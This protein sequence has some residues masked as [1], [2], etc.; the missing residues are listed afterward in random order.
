MALRSWRET[1]LGGKEMKVQLGGTEK[2]F[3]ILRFFSINAPWKGSQP[4]VFPG[5]NGKF[6]WPAG[7][8]ADRSSVGLGHPRDM[9]IGWW[10]S[11]ELGQ[12]PSAGAW[13]GKF[14]PLLS[15]F[16]FAPGC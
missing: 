1:A 9:A 6:F 11:G 12:S 3:I 16:I 2:A 15:F 13:T 7:A 10:E 4:R 14:S 5:T 8:F